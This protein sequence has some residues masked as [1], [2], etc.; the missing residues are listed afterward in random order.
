MDRGASSALRRHDPRK[1]RL[2]IP[3]TIFAGKH[4]REM[5]I[6]CAC[7]ALYSQQQSHIAGGCGKQGRRRRASSIV[8]A[9]TT[10]S[11]G[12]AHSRCKALLVTR[13]GGRGS[14]G[15]KSWLGSVGSND[16]TYDEFPE[17]FDY[18]DSA[19][20]P[21]HL[22]DDDVIGSWSEL[23][24][25]SGKDLEGAKKVKGHAAKVAT[26]AET[27]EEGGNIGAGSKRSRRL[28]S[29]LRQLGGS[30]RLC[31]RSVP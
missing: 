30:R 17:D 19:Y 16:D 23:E 4:T 31:G 15:S 12:R 8:T 24:D 22:S 3:P 25:E 26:T 18:E 1:Q 29:G 9:I 27:G 20:D 14:G 7:D 11:C 28:P 5:T 10:V 13:G 2:R 6:A 21:D